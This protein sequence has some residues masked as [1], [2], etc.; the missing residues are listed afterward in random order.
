MDLVFKDTL[1]QRRSSLSASGR[2]PLELYVCGPT[3]YSA[4]H[5]GHLRTYLLFDTVRRFFQAQGKR[6]HYVRNFTDFE[7]KI[8]QRAKVE[9]IGWRQVSLRETKD[10]TRMMDRAGI[11]P[12]DVSPASSHFVRPMIEVIRKLER[13]G[14]TYSRNGSVYFDAS[15][16]TDRNNFSAE[17]F[18]SAHAVAEP[19]LS[20]LPEANDPRDF[21]LWKPSRKPAPE[22]PSPWGRGMPGWHIECFVMSS[23]YMH[24]PMDLHGGGLDLIFPHHYAE[25]LISL[26]MTNHLISRNFIHSAFVTMDA[27]KMAKSTGN[28]VGIRE[29]L[30]IVSP[31]GLRYYLMGKG[32]EERLEFS[33][34]EAHQAEEEW[35]MLQATLED[36]VRPGGSSGFP[37]GRI[38]AAATEIL[39]VLGDNIG[40]PEALTVLCELA[41][42]V[43]RSGYSRIGRGELGQA[44]KALSQITALTGLP[45]LRAGPTA[46]A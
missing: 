38:E 44:R 11:L 3:V 40:T 29:A 33:L 18:L 25:N 28:L 37:V 35:S 9:G 39:R 19:G 20:A 42:D 34:F 4:A 15:R 31:G 26:A 36:L 23:S 30:D 8:T 32:Y 24:L 6:V 22:W 13:T 14:F 17:D 41:R 16:V 5:V 1:T 7:D 27:R 21:V 45:V 12:P 46:G 2:S 10:F 43:R